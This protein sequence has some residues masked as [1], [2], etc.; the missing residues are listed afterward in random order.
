MYFEVDDEY[1]TYLCEDNANAFLVALLP[2][3]V[4]HNYNVIVKDKIS[5]RLYYQITTYLLPLLCES[6]N[7]KP[8]NI[9]CDLTDKKYNG[10]AVGT[11]ISCGVDSFYTLFKHNNLKDKTKNI[12]HLCFFNAGSNG[13]FGG[14]EARELYKKRVN[15]IERFCKKYK[16]PL[17]KVDSNMNELIMMRHEKR[18]TFTTLACVYV[19]EKLFNTYYFP[20]GLSFNNSHIDEIDTAYY[21][22]LNVECL[23]NENILF[24]CSG[25]EVT[26]M[27]KIEFISNFK[28]TYK[29]LNVCVGTKE[30]C[31]CTKCHKCLRTITA[32]ES[33][34]KLDNYSSV[35]DL[36]YYYKNRKKLLSNLIR[37][38]RNRLEGV[39][40]K[41][42]INSYKKNNVKI[43]FISYILS[44]RITKKNIKDFIKKIIH[45]K[46]NKINDGWAD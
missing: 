22:I 1:K 39:F 46:P 12:T 24:Y 6:F 13:D 26:R 44:Y 20:S 33:I 34:K 28:E 4:K 21:D 45:K 11:S 17:I 41:E 25:L 7:K 30:W 15:K 18:H 31:N 14:E 35:F 10:K 42:I 19:F 36:G 2:F 29:W 23:S 40:S 43:P 32:L 3:I 37:E 5:S 16:Y 8:I 38:N 27:K 9:T